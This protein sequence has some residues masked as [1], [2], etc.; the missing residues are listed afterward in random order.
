MD[1]MEKVK[2]SKCGFMNLKG[3][4]TCSKCHTNIESYKKSCPKCGKVNSNNVKRCIN[5]N[6]DF[7]KKR[8]NLGNLIISLALVIILM[9][10]V[11]FDKENIVEKF[12]FVLKVFAGFMIF[13]L[14]VNT[15]TYG[16]KEKINYSA[17]DEI[18]DKHKKFNNM[19]KKSRVAIVLGLIISA[20]II[21][22]Y[23]FVR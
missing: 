10:L 13:L 16:S 8:S 17:E 1:N 20:I 7:M 21:V 18:I 3:T 9:L 11:Y 5:C 22:I 12:S 19:K 15:I 6:F 4:R 2:C 23:Y 14:I